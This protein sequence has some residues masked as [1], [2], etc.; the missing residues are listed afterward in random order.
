MLSS[1]RKVYLKPR[2]LRSCE[3]DRVAHLFAQ[4]SFFDTI[5]YILPN[6]AKATLANRQGHLQLAGEQ[7]NRE[8]SI[9]FF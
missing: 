3:Y 2:R 7:P 1:Q 8:L 6:V 9:A 4:R 5:Y